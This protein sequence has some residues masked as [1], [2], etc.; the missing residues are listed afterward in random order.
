MNGKTYRLRCGDGE[1]ARLS[2]LADYLSLRI[3]RLAMDFGQHGDERLLLMA[4]LLVTD[5]M[6]DLKA[7]LKSLEGA[8]DIPDEQI[9]GRDIAP[10]AGAPIEPADDPEVADAES[11]PAPTA[12]KPPPPSIARSTTSLRTSLEARL[13]EAR[14]E[15]PTGASSKRRPGAA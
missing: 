10:D 14:G 8:P 13:A 4:A 3:E 15:K 1:E 2:E 12:E 11:E 9:T 7:R 5:E 6:L